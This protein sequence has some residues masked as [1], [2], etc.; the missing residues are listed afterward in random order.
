M[1]KGEIMD[2][3]EFVDGLSNFAFRALMDA[4]II[5]IDNHTTQLP[6]MLEIERDL[7][8]N[9]RIKAIKYVK[10]RLNLGLKEAKDLVDKEV[11]HQYGKNSPKY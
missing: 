1:H 10:T 4:C 5:R 7:A 8:V 11:P 6:V 3:K 9:D 2:L